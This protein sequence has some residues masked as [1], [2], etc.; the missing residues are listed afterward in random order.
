VVVLCCSKAQ[1]GTRSGV[2]HCI[3]Q[4]KRET[5]QT[6]QISFDPPNWGRL[7]RRWLRQLNSMIYIQRRALPK[8]RKEYG[9]CYAV[10]CGCGC[11]IVVAVTRG[12]YGAN[13]S[14]GSNIENTTKPD[15]VTCIH[16]LSRGLCQMQVAA[17]TESIIYNVWL[18]RSALRVVA[19][20]CNQ[21]GER[22]STGS[23]FRRRRLLPQVAIRWKPAGILPQ[24]A[25]SV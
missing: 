20:V 23:L 25:R 6:E 24:V 10:R 4:G 1:R 9:A 12:E 16:P 5:N 15:Q 17:A 11:M 7:S 3:T 13:K 18:D 21:I 14:T 19:V 22:Q 2:K 8:A